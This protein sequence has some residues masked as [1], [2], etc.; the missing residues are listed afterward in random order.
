MVI[1][2]S[3]CSYRSEQCLLSI[4]FWLA[5]IISTSYFISSDYKCFKNSSHSK[6]CATSIDCWPLMLYTFCV[7]ITKLKQLCLWSR[8]QFV[9]HLKIVQIIFQTE[10]VCVRVLFLPLDEIETKTVAS[11]SL[12]DKLV[13]KD[14]V[15]IQTLII[16]ILILLSSAG[17][18]VCLKWLH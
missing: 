11:M 10:R 12:F 2:L 6:W 18:N 3:K 16:C 14:A 5:F 13:I 7:I 17:V 9:F 4:F 1:D 8:C 15:E